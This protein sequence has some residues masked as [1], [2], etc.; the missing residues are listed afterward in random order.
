MSLAPTHWPGAPRSDLRHTGHTLATQSGATLKDAMVRA[1]QS[2][3][4]AALIYQHSNRQ[5]QREIANALDGKVREE[6]EAETRKRQAQ[7]P[8][9]TERAREQ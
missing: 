1:G 9:G 4:R 2:S 6:R 7:S 3:E 5:R 8:S